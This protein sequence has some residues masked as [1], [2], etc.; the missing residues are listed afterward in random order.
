MLN[1]VALGFSP[2]RHAWFSRFP[3]IGVS[4]LIDGM[5]L[6]AAQP[7]LSWKKHKSKPRAVH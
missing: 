1:R 7:L 4:P 2:K 3:Q 5:G 6:L